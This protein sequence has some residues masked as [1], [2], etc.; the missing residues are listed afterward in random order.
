MN[1]TAEQLLEAYRREEPIYR[2]VLELVEQ[3]AQMMEQEPDPSRVL[4]LCRRVEGLMDQIE[5]IEEALQPAKTEWERSGTPHQ[6]LDELLAAIEGHIERTAE[7]QERVQQ[8]LLRY[9]EQQK[10]ST[11]QTRA[12]IKARRADRLYRAG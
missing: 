3:Q 10:R 2:R 7:M 5:T 9:V 12:Q 11:E 8:A 6:A 1:D 4:A